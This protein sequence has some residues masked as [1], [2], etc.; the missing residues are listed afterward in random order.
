LTP[1]SKNVTH[2]AEKSLK[3]ALCR[4]L[5][6]YSYRP[7]GSVINFQKK[8][9]EIMLFLE[10]NE[11][12]AEKTKKAQALYHEALDFLED[13]MRHWKHFPYLRVTRELAIRPIYRVQKN[14]LYQEAVYSGDFEHAEGFGDIKY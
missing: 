4:N 11:F 13:F 9:G 1:T 8:G 6:V 2:F 12:E 14:P 3:L 5:R 10:K 7:R